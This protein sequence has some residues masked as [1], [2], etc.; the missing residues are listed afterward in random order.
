MTTMGRYAMA[1]Q[2]AVGVLEGRVKLG[3][4][5][6]PAAIDDHPDRGVRLADDRPHWMP[7]LAP[8]L[9]LTGRH[10]VREACGG[11]ILERP[12]D[13]EPYAAR[14]T[15]PRAIRQPRLAC[16]GCLACDLTLAQG[17]SGEASPLCCAPPA[18]AGQ[19]TA[20]QDGGVC[21]EPNALPTASLVRAGGKVK[22][23]ISEV[24]G[25]GIAPSGGAAGASR[26]FFHRQRT[27]S[28]PR[29]PPV[30]WA[31]TGARAR[32]LPGEERAPCARGA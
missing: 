27:R 2:R 6:A 30:C 9:G 5:L 31:H 7:I 20:P 18:R 29:W 32:H 16:E 17:A 13:T 14:Q 11:A 4:P 19:R 1:A 3:R 21:I 28:R 22:S 12:H 24:S 25:G 23:P 15:A 10:N 26:G 8:L